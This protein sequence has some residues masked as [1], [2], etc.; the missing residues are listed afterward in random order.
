MTDDLQLR[1]DLTGAA[2]RLAG[3]Q[4]DASSRIDG[5]STQAASRAAFKRLGEAR[6]AA[7]RAHEASR[8]PALGHGRTRR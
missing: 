2:A 4:Q 8:T 5:S 1:L 7:G 6:E 3:R